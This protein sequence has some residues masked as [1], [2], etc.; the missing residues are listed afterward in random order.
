VDDSSDDVHSAETRAKYRTRLT[1][2]AKADLGVQGLID[3]LTAASA[4]DAGLARRALADVAARVDQCGRVRLLCADAL[5]RLGDTGCGS[6][7]LLDLV[8]D[9]RTD[10]ES[11]VRAVVELA[12]LGLRVAA[13]SAVRQIARDRSLPPGTR[14]SA[15]AALWTVGRRA[16]ADRVFSE[17]LDSDSTVSLKLEITGFLRAQ[18]L[19]AKVIE[20]LMRIV[21]DESL[22]DGLRRDALSQLAEP[23]GNVALV[24]AA[25]FIARSGRAGYGLAEDAATILANNAD[26][27][28]IPSLLQCC[29]ATATTASLIGRLDDLRV[30]RAVAADTRVDVSLRI[31]AARIRFDLHGAKADAEMIAALVQQAQS[32]HAACERGI[33]TS[34]PI[35]DQTTM[36][37]EVAKALTVLTRRGFADTAITLWSSIAG[38]AEVSVALRLQAIRSLVDS[39]VRDVATAASLAI[40]RDSGNA[41]WQRL[42]ALNCLTCLEETASGRRDRG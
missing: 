19:V 24:R 40:A 41:G 22:E 34:A 12:V 8:R 28:A 13:V 18:D 32:V 6:V 3:I 17:L 5:L 2:S 25:R 23:P 33:G 27:E 31:K 38:C 11:R 37:S 10:R 26:R 15:S 42:E 9:H 36:L 16:E 30:L 20:P 14:F 35:S 39:G 21:R 29:G 1:N 7:A 4:E